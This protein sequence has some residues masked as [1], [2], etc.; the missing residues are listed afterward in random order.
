M[1]VGNQKPTAEVYCVIKPPSKVTAEDILRYQV[2]LVAD[3]TDYCGDAL[4]MVLC[5]VGYPIYVC[6]LSGFS[7]V[8]PSQW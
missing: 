8:S 3:Q 4:Y 6:L 1:V 7:V 2:R 5:C